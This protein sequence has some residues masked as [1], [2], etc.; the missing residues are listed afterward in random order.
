MAENTRD[1][2][3]YWAEKAKEKS[4]NYSLNKMKNTEHRSNSGQS[5][6]LNFVSQEKKDNLICLI[7]FK[8]KFFLRLGSNSFEF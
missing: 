6:L 3:Y 7:F 5:N 1:E 2:G 8:F 4:M